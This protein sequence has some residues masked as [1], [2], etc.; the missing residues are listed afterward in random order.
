M[1]LHLIGAAQR[2]TVVPTSRP[3]FGTGTDASDLQMYQAMRAM[4][5]RRPTGRGTP[6]SARRSSTSSTWR[7]RSSGHY[8]ADDA[9]PESEIVARL[10]IAARMINANLGFRVLTVGFGDFDS[11]ANQPDDAHRRGCRS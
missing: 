10:E 1:P 7:R 5:T 4:R 2:G 3:S 9:L 6:P 8:P 11:H